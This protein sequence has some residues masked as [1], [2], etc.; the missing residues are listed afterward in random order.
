MYLPKP[1]PQLPDADRA[2]HPSWRRY[3]RKYRRKQAI[4]KN[5]WI[6]SGILMIGLPM[7]M[8]VIALGT[9]L[10]AFMILDETP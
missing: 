10:L 2:R 1:P 4:V 5:V 3:T 7:A 9:T 8:P 6:V